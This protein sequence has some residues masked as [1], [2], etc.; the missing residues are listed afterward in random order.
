M[1][2]KDKLT[3]F[4]ILKV[5]VYP[6]QS[7]RKLHQKLR[8]YNSKQIIWLRSSKEVEDFLAQQEPHT[9]EKRPS[10][11]TPSVGRKR[12]LGVVRQQLPERFEAQFNEANKGKL[13]GNILSLWA[14]SDYQWD[15]DV[16][17]ASRTR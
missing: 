11:K 8:N 4:L 16:L 17:R 3:F 7:R 12:Q 2:S 6:F 14:N 9:H 5:L 13:H 1:G 10:S 15:A